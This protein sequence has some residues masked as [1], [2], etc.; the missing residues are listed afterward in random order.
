MRNTI[1]YLRVVIKAISSL[2]AQKTVT[3]TMIVT[4]KT[5]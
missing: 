1:F 4:N 2:P 3:D 5:D